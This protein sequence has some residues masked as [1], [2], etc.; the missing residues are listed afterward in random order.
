MAEQRNNSGKS[1]DGGL[2]PPIDRGDFLA[3]FNKLE[4]PLRSYLYSVTC[5]VHDMDD[6]AQNVWRVLWQKF[7][8]YDRSRPFSA[9]AFGVARLEALKW[10]QRKAR[11][12]LVL[13]EEATSRLAQTAAE[14]APEIDARSRF[15]PECLDA[16][17]FNYRQVLDLKYAV[18]LKIAAIAER[19]GRTVPAVEMALVRARRRLRACVRNKMRV[20]GMEGA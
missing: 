6:L 5:N 17:N 18:G 3:C 13:D 8:E 10:R 11:S 4:R 9:W 15:L 19:L 16:L 20:Q 1:K 12:R 7:D 2:H 14:T